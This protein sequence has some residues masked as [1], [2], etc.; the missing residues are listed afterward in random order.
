MTMRKL[1]RWAQQQLDLRLSPQQLQAFSRYQQE[2]LRWNQHTNLTAIREP[3][4]VITKHFLDSLSVLTATGCLN[5]QR[6][7]DVGSGAG[8]PGLVLKIACPA[9]RLTLIESVGKKA[10]FCR[11]IVQTLDLPEV[12]VLA[13][14]AETAGHMADHREAYDW[15]M[16]RA[17]ARLPILAEYLLPLVKPG[18]GMLAQ[19]GET[20]AAEAE[21]AA[22]AL[23]ILGGKLENILPVELP[24]VA[25]PRYLVVI[26]KTGVTPE[27]YPRRAGVPAKRPL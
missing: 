19:K 5:G 22:H 15:A 8:F 23:Q 21:D 26:R 17:V 2:L 27:R 13:E 16:A 24:G 1:S 14:R 18:G 25:E 10:D 6:V 12:T 20:A 3:D 4:Q 9:M 7:A 11:H